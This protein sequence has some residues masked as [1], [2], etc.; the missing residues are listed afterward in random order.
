MFSEAC[1]SAA[2]AG[3]S[4]ATLEKETWS[5]DANATEIFGIR[6]GCDTLLCDLVNDFLDASVYFTLY[7]DGFVSRVCSSRTDDDKCVSVH[8]LFHGIRSPYLLSSCA[9]ATDCI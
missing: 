9:P 3:S 1:S 4:I 5:L 6:M 2:C 7:D 8:P